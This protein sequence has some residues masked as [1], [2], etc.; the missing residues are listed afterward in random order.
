MLPMHTSKEKKVDALK[1]EKDIENEGYVDNLCEGCGCMASSKV[2][3][4]SLWLLNHGYGC[5]LELGLMVHIV[6]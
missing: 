2:L 5:L 1:G 3:I 4:M 6:T